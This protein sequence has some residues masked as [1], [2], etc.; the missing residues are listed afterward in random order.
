M[1][2]TSGLCKT[3]LIFAGLRLLYRQHFVLRTHFASFN[4]LKVLD[5]GYNG[6]R[7]LDVNIL[8]CSVMTECYCQNI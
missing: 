2:P 5:F 3:R 1:A 8:G 4:D 6:T 7:R